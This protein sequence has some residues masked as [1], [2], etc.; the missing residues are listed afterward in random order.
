MGILVEAALCWA[1]RCCQILSVCP[2]ADLL[3]SLYATVLW[4]KYCDYGEECLETGC[5]LVVTLLLVDFFLARLSVIFL[6][7]GAC[8]NQLPGERRLGGRALAKA[9]N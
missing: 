1:L 9:P 4:S 7:H 3:V 8:S 6:S 2:N 5:A